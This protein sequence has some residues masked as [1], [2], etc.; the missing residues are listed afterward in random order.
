MSLAIPPNPIA[1]QDVPSVLACI[2]APKLVA[3]APKDIPSVVG[4]T[5]SV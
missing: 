1:Y 2:L 3:L 5:A 4:A